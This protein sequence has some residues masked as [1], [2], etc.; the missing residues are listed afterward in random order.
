MVFVD[1]LFL[2]KYRF[3]GQLGWILEPKMKPRGSQKWTKNHSKKELSFSINWKSILA[4]F[5]VPCWV[6]RWT[7]KWSRRPS[8]TVPKI[9]QK[10]CQSTKKSATEM[11][12][13]STS[14]FSR[15]GLHLG[16]SCASQLKPSWP[17]WLPKLTMSALK[18]LLLAPPG[19][20]RQKL[21]A[22]SWYA[23]RAH[24]DLPG[25]SW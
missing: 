14:I 12:C 18:S 16:G 11:A 25:K 17:F 22:D 20:L 6:P 8:K 15:F 19:P 24:Q 21:I 13:F 9:S 1:L 7:K 5:W 23:Q 10:P 3:G 4:P 2:H